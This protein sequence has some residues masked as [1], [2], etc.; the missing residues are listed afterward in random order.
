[1]STRTGMTKAVKPSRPEDQHEADNPF[2]AVHPDRAKKRN[3]PR[4]VEDSESITLGPVQELH[5]R[6]HANQQTRMRAKRKS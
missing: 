2:C 5:R 6:T 4:T 1:M 3:R